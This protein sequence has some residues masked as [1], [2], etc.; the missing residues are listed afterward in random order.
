MVDR[1]FLNADLGWRNFD[2]VDKH[3]TVDHH[4]PLVSREGILRI[5]T[6]GSRTLLEVN[7]F[8]LQ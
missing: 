8:K 3:D 7:Y 2:L 4:T 5:T 6:P 1:K